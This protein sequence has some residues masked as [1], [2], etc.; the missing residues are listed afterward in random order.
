MRLA[1]NR[2]QAERRTSGGS[3]F[4]M[5]GIVLG[6]AR[7]AAGRV[8]SFV[9]YRDQQDQN[10]PEHIASLW[11]LQESSE[12]DG[13]IVSNLA[14]LAGIGR[15]KSALARGTPPATTTDQH[16]PGGASAHASGRIQLFLR[17]AMVNDGF[18]L[19]CAM[20]I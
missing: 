4:A 17:N 1:P 18:G 11:V 7:A 10:C 3:F 19:F 15:G 8:E 20:D 16:S 5:E 2:G 12:L 9:A 6:E 14:R 13:E